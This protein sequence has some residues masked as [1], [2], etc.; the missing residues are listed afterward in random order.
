MM[1]SRPALTEFHQ[2]VETRGSLRPDFGRFGYL[3][4]LDFHGTTFA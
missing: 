1:Y 2:A 3:S 4:S